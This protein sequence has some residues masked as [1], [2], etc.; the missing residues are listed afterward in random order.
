MR[1]KLCSLGLSIIAL[2]RD[3][4]NLPAPLNGTVIGNQTTYPNKLTFL[5]DEGFDLVGSSVL[6]CKADGYWNERQPICNG[7]VD[8]LSHINWIDLCSGMF[9]HV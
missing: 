7:N 1:D 4:A 3:C 2:A 9:W 8:I 6:Q 5:C